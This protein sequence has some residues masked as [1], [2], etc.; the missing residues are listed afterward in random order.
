MRQ[1]SEDEK[2]TEAWEHDKGEKMQ[3]NRDAEDQ[4]LATLLQALSQVLY[5]KDGTYDLTGDFNARAQGAAA[6]T[7]TNVAAYLAGEQLPWRGSLAE[8]IRGS[9]ESLVKSLTEFRA[10]QA[11]AGELGPKA[12]QERYEAEK[13]AAAD[14]AT[15]GEGE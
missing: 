12:N 1:R 5:D 3:R 4:A 14:A 15:K 6:W 10:E 7:A 11:A 8:Q 2:E 9:H 13:A